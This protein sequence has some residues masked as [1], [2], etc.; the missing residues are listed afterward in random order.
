MIDK[1][2]EINLKNKDSFDKLDMIEELEV[3]NC[4][5][6]DYYKLLDYLSNDKD[7]EVRAKVAE[8][9]VAPNN[10]EADKILIK[11]LRDKDE[12]VRVNACDSLCTS[13]SYDVINHLKDT[14]LKDKS[15]LVKGYAI[16]SLA[17]IVIRLN[18]DLSEAIEFLK[19]TLQIQRV[20]LVRINIYKAL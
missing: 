15:N 12:L 10:S 9:L 1:Y 4:N 7:Y 17:D 11:L 19:S 3:T 20:Q 14:I 5:T 8:V 2:L 13:N 6:A 16:L 18:N